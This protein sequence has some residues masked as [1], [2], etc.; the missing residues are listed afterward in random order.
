MSEENYSFALVKIKS[1][2][3]NN[4]SIKLKNIDFFLF[5]D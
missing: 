3:M 1:S 5:F 4:L 2:Y